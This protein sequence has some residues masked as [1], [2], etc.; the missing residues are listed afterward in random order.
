MMNTGKDFLKF[1]KCFSWNWTWFTLCTWLTPEGNNYFV[2]EVEVEVTTIRLSFDT[3]WCFAVPFTSSVDDYGHNCDLTLDILVD[4]DNYWRF[5]SADSIVRFDD[6]VARESKFGWC[7][8]S[9]KES[10]SHQLL[11][12][13]TANYVGESELHN[14]LLPC[15][16]G[17][18]RPKMVSFHSLQSTFLPIQ[19]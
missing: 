10:V 12:I 4:V 16:T 13:S 18:S 9:H 5:I 7:L 1:S 19:E 17:S 14:H 15:P 2:V 3:L 11:C 8:T 6:L